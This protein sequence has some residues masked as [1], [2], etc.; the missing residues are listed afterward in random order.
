MHKAV[1]S[2]CGKDCEVP[3]EP[4]KGKPVYC[5]EC[6]EKKG[7]GTDLNKFQGRNPRR[8]YFERRSESRPPDYDKLEAINRKLDKILEMLTILT[9]IKEEKETKAKLEEITSIAQKKTKAP[10]KKTPVE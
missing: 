4:T 5:S 8:P 3:F 10:K 9:P 1:C 6:F 2:E 7:G